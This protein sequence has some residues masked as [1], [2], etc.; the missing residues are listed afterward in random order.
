MLRS[1]GGS[2]VLYPLY[3]NSSLNFHQVMSYRK[4]KI[5]IG[6]FLWRQKARSICRQD[7]RT[8]MCM[9]IM[10]V[11]NVF[12]SHRHT[13]ISSTCSAVNWL[14]FSVYTYSVAKCPRS[15]LSSSGDFSWRAHS[16]AKSACNGTTRDRNSFPLEAGSVSHRY[17]NFGF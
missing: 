10:L 6:F 9:R 7:G 2:V 8:N 14:M 15:G 16:T 4:T 11:L 3:D 17:L 13:L 1:I 5:V 12:L